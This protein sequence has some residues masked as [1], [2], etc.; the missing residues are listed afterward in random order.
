MLLYME[1]KIQLKGLKVEFHFKKVISSKLGV[2][3]FIFLD[4]WSG[5]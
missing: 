5:S 3:I 4:S 1:L 2:Y